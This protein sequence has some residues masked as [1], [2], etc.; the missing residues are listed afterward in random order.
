MRRN[1]I[2]VGIAC[3]AVLCVLLFLRPR[4]PLGVALGRIR[5]GMDET[6]VTA[7]LGSP[8]D[9]A[10][11]ATGP[12]GK[13]AGHTLAWRYGDGFLFVEFDEDG[14]AVHIQSHGEG[15]PVWERVKGWRPW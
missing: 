1:R 9:S 5:V 8:T 10:I 14:K 7:A 15:R 4:D 13:P 6:A 12:D 11:S 2:L 3:L